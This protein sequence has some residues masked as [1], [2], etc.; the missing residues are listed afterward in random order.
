M[1]IPLNVVGDIIHP[2][3]VA[4][5]YYEDEYVRSSGSIEASRLYLKDI[6]ADDVVEV[7]TYSGGYASSVAEASEQAAANQDYV[8]QSR[9]IIETTYMPLM[10]EQYQLGVDAV[11]AKE[12]I[13]EILADVNNINDY[14]YN[15]NLASNFAGYTVGATFDYT[16]PNS[17]QVEQR[18]SAKHFANEAEE[19]A[20]TAIVSRDSVIQH[21]TAALNAQQEAEN[22]A[23]ASRDVLNG[24]V[25]MNNNTIAT[26]GGRDTYLIAS[27]KMFIEAEDG[28]FIN[29]VPT[30]KRILTLS[31]GST[32][33]L[34][35]VG[36]G[37]DLLYQ[38][39]FYNMT[40]VSAGVYEFENPSGLT[41]NNINDYIIQLQY[42]SDAL[43]FPRVNKETDKFTVTVV[44]LAGQ[45]VDTGDLAIFVYDI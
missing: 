43:C 28:V 42:Q 15:A 30:P 40:R 5:Y 39:T 21:K 33:E 4:D 29:S 41:Y 10:A 2:E 17:Q 26:I 34:T 44:D 7:V 11:E 27:S 12:D 19:A 16:N 25:Q 35:G 13:D 3:G 18:Y 45:P 20:N 9:D 22:A 23:N 8:Q 31:M 38:R 6:Q 37:V 14:I 36:V 24:W 32:P 1:I